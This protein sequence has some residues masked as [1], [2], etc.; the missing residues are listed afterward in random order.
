MMFSIFINQHPDHR[1]CEFH[2]VT[3][4]TVSVKI[5]SWALRLETLHVM[6]F[7]TEDICLALLLMDWLIRQQQQWP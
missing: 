2:R 7:H 3:G 5:V 4:K 6:G 1:C